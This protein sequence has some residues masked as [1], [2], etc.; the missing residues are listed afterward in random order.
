M[1]LRVFGHSAELVVFWIYLSCSYPHLPVNGPSTLDIVSHGDQHKAAP[2][3]FQPKTSGFTDPVVQFQDAEYSF[4][5][6]ADT[7]PEAVLGFLFRAQP[8]AAPGFVQDTVGNAL[9]R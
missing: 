3:S 7:R 5:R 6:A 4:H 8:L 9:S 2:V 1:P